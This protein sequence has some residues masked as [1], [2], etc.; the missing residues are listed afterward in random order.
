MKRKLF[1]IA[2]LI[3]VSILL[4]GCAPKNKEEGISTSKED[5]SQEENLSG[6]LLDLVKLGKNV[7]C[8]F[9]AKDENGESIGTTYVSGNKSRSDFI[10]TTSDGQEFESHSITDNDWIYIWTS[11]TEQGT[12]MKLSELPK[13]DEIDKV[14]KSESLESFNENFDYKCSKWIVDESKFNVP[15]NITFVDFTEIMKNMQTQTENLKENLKGMCGAC[16]LAGDT[17]KAAECKKS[18]GC[19]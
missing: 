10:A 7:K 12:K 11:Q 3:L 4:T 8:T 9:G 5:S 18:L 6:S 19:E 2:G 14:S 1:S 16:D 17:D 15:S 13:N